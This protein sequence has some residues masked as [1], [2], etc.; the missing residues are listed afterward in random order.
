MTESS[1]TPPPLPPAELVIE[2]FRR[3][4]D[5]KFLASMQ[6]PPHVPDVQWPT[7]E[8][9]DFQ[10]LFIFRNSVNALKKKY[11]ETISPKLGW[12]S[13]LSDP[14]IS[15]VTRMTSA[16]SIPTN[17]DAFWRCLSDAF[18][19][20]E[21]TVIEAM[22]RKLAS[23]DASDDFSLAEVHRFLDAF[24]VA[25]RL[26]QI[27]ELTA[28]RVYLLEALHSAPTLLNAV[29]AHERQHPAA[30]FDA[31]VTLVGTKA[32]GVI[33]AR[34]VLALPAS[35]P[36]VRSV[37][38]VP[39][40]PSAPSVS[41][42][43]LV[44]APV[45]VSDSVSA[46]ASVSAPSSAPATAAAAAGSAPDSDATSAS[47]LRSQDRKARRCYYCHRPGH[48]IAECPIRPESGAPRHSGREVRP[49]DRLA[50][51]E[52]P[53][54]ERPL[55]RRA[56]IGSVTLADESEQPAV[57][58]GITNS[59]FPVRAV[60]DSGAAVSASSLG[61]MRN[62]VKER[63]IRPFSPPV[64]T[65]LADGSERRINKQTDLGFY[66]HDGEGSRWVSLER[67]LLFDGDHP[68]YVLIGQPD[69]LRNK[70]NTADM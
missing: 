69:L 66:T 57:I 37:P 31:L 53:R 7:F 49:P 63:E 43:K 38:S 65:V 52:D 2:F 26:L 50:P 54:R 58:T 33:S 68:N 19:P 59:G 46:S 3:F 70:L 14:V 42:R 25:A 1:P 22:L 60:C 39:S 8:I 13:V 28:L 62:F 34:E 5:P 24:S 36:S 64:V 6:P 47:E 56:P 9:C 48:A 11:G 32:K 30:D 61:Y 67:I 20:T 29:T 45:S 44:S 17:E 15:V 35:V 21:P 41:A 55:E 18:A 16:K 23:F 51:T 27:T 40:V 4:S 12:S 10:H